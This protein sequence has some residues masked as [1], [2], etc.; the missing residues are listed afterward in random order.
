ML[1]QFTFDYTDKN[2]TALKNEYKTA[3]GFVNGYTVTEAVLNDLV[4]FATK[5]GLKK[6]EDGLKLSAE[7]IK[8][9]LK[10]YIGRN[11]FDDEAFYPVIQTVDKTLKKAVSV[12]DTLK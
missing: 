5:S 11:I 2:S 10:A 9:Y 7:N 12:L 4:E 6:N 8:V 1:L 3:I